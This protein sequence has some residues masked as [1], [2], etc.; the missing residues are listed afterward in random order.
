MAIAG[1]RPERPEFIETL[2]KEIPFYG[3]R[4]MARPGVTGWAQ[5]KYK[6]VNTVEDAREKIQHHLFYI[7]NTSIGRDLLIMFQTIKMV[8]LHRGAFAADY[9]SKGVKFPPMGV[10]HMFWRSGSVITGEGRNVSRATNETKR[11]R[12]R[13]KVILTL[14]LS[15]APRGFLVS[16][17][18][19]TDRRADAHSRHRLA[20]T[21][22]T[23]W[24]SRD[25]LLHEPGCTRPGCTAK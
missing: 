19:P 25:G 13:M 22:S 15:G 17:M 18:L 12:G 5:I 24:D 2:S 8:W 16:Y 3:V 6:H 23:S 9:F 10:K 20:L 4:H 11:P 1:P 21:G 14:T 7:K